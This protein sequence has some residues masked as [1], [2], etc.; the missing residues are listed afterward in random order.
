LI[1]IFVSSLITLEN[2]FYKA[3]VMLKI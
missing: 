3:L 2:A 1:E